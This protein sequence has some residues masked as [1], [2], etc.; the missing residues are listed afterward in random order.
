MKKLLL[1]AILT[2]GIFST[3]SVFAQLFPGAGY[4]ALLQHNTNGQIIHVRANSLE[5]CRAKVQEEINNNPNYFAVRRCR[6][7][8]FSF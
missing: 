2:F 5:S 6:A 4:Q 8:I 1:S 3:S 7:S